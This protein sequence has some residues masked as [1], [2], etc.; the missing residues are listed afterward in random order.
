MAPEAG[1][2]TTGTYWPYD[3]FPAGPGAGSYNS[4]VT[5]YVSTIVL[6]Y[7]H[8]K[9]AVTPAL[10]FSA[11]QR[12]GYPLS[13]AGYDPATCGT[14]TS[15]PIASAWYAT[16][17]GSGSAANPATCGSTIDIPDINTGKFDGIGAFVEPARFTLSAQFSYDISP[18]VTAVLTMANIV[19]ACLGGSST[20]WTQNV[21]SPLP[22]YKVCGYGTTSETENG[23]APGNVN[24]ISPTG[25]QLSQAENAYGYSP[26]VLSLPFNAYLDFR[27]RL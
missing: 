27:L 5:P 2:S 15:V 19:D 7:K 10:Q 23:Y 22:G 1:F 24:A 9:W 21:A 13:E 3:L 26:S 11:G 18:R 16:A 6:N 8:N 20:A 25:A 14:P 17:G 4:F 12:Y